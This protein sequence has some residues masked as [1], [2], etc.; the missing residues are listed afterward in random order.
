[1]HYHLEIIMPP[2]K[3]IEKAVGKILKPYNENREDSYNAF[4]D[5]WVIG[6]RYSG[7]HVESNLDPEILSRF[8]DRVVEEKI[9]V[10]GLVCGKQKISP[11]EQIQFVDKLWWEYFP[12]LEGEPCLLF[13]HAGDNIQ[14][15]IKFKDIGKHLTAFRVIFANKW[16]DEGKRWDVTDMYTTECWNGATHQSTDWSGN[17]LEIIERQKNRLSNGFYS[18]EFVKSVMPKDDWLCVTVDYHS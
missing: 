11:P 7:S 16:H 13:D 2:C 10:S 5:W 14:E 18:E 6:G 4:W 3:N 1:M 15:I 8:W 17:V 9:T 12:H